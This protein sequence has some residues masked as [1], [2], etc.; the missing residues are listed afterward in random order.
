MR[1]PKPFSGKEAT[2]EKCL[3]QVEEILDP[4][5]GITK[6]E[7]INVLSSV[8]EGPVLDWWR[9][10]RSNIKTWEQAKQALI[11]QYGDKFIEDNS[12]RELEDLT[13][14]GRIQDYL[15]ELDCLN[16]HVGLGN[17]ALLALINRKIKPK[18][19]EMMAPFH[20]M[21]TEDPRGWMNVLVSCGDALEQNNSLNCPLPDK[22]RYDK[23]CSGPNSSRQ[24][25][26]GQNSSNRDNKKDFH[27][28]K[29]KSGQQKKEFV[30]QEK[31]KKRKLEGHC[32]RCG[33]DGHAAD[34]C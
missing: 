11:P 32:E 28:H 13:Q 24:N 26:S 17:R 2:L 27:D 14:S 23:G 16:G 4:Y 18:L 10:H 9:K 31:Q 1:L 5:E 29:G 20:S 19:Q 15:A 34:D 6:F 33:K 7:T 22:N 30:S 12:R 25:S 8:L 21:W 3:F